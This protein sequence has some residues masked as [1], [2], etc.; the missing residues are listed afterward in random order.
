MDRLQALEATLDKFVLDPRYHDILT[1]VKGVRNG[2]VYGSKVRFPHALVYV[3]RPP[4]SSSESLPHSFQPPL[5][6]QAS[7]AFADIM[8]HVV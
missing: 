1:L 5:V 6:H 7:F 3:P 8:Y 4:F 2:I